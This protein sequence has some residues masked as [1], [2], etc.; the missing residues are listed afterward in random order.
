MGLIYDKNSKELH[1]LALAGAA[2]LMV[3]LVEMVDKVSAIGYKRGYNDGYKRYLKE[4]K[5]AN[6]NGNN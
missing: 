6:K 3:D 5:G 2:H 1:D 4:V